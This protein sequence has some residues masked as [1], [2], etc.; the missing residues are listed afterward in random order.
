MQMQSDGGAFTCRPS[1]AFTAS[2][3]AALTWS[4]AAHHVTWS[5]II[6]HARPHARSTISAPPA[7]DWSS[8]SNDA[9]VMLRLLSAT[10]TPAPPPP[11]TCL[12]PLMWWWVAT[13]RLSF[14]QPVPTFL[15]TH[16]PLSSPPPLPPLSSSFTIK[17]STGSERPDSSCA[18]SGRC[19]HTSARWGPGL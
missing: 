15:F 5:Y 6:T 8:L 7:P 4:D 17:S 3:T 14:P 12:P 18:S 9:E 10:Q 13:R 1:A 2:N 16:V 11:T 19:R